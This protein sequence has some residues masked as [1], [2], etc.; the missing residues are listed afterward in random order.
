MFTGTLTGIVGRDPELRCLDNGSSVANFTVA[1]RQP[2]RGGTEPPTRWVRVS[3]WGKAAQFVAD[4]IRKGDR[5]LC[6]GD[7]P[8][9]ELYQ[10]RDGQQKLSE[11]FKAINVEKLSAPSG[12]AA[13]GGAD[14]GQAAPAAAPTPAAA[15]AAGGWADEEPPF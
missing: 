3:I 15:P 13:G 12:G 6:W 10:T 7:V 14:G 8:A 9:P 2:R 1:V 5:V 4:Y 11:N